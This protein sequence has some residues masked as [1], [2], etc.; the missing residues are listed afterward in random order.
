MGIANPLLDSASDPLT[1]QWNFD[2]ISANIFMTSQVV[3]S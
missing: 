1:V 2:V 3:E